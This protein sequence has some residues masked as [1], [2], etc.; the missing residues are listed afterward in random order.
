MW[1]FERPIAH[2]GLHND[3]MTENSMASFLHAIEKNYNIETDVHLLKSGEVVIFHDFNLKRVCGKK[4]KIS[5]L[6]LE[7]I[8]SDN[9]LLPNGE[10]IPL[11]SELME[12]AEGK[13]GILLELKFGGFSYELERAVLKLIE[14]KEHFIAIQ[15][16]NPMTIIWFKKHAPQFFA[17]SLSSSEVLLL[18]KLFFR[19]TKPD[20]LAYNVKK[21]RVAQKHFNKDGK[22]NMLSWTVKTKE[23][24]DESVKYKVNNII[25][26]HLDL[27]QEDV[28]SQLQKLKK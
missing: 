24:V 5:D 25:F 23:Q 22:L 10:H 26:E 16:F 9:Y 2:R 20:F 28:T 27:E 18:T 21:L 15:A 6:T 11:F 1:L 4:V 8:K 3:T 13:T 19:K 12:V 7:D 17:G 14:G